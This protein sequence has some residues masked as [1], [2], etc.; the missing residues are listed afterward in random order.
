[1]IWASSLQ[2][3]KHGHSGDFYHIILFVGILQ[4]PLYAIN[5]DAVRLFAVSSF[6]FLAMLNLYLH[7]M[8]CI[9]YWNE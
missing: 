5:M 8:Y 1:M 4:L 9:N 7:V 3:R 2:I 6:L